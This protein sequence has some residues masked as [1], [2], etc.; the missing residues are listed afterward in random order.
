MKLESRAPRVR[1]WQHHR[2]AG[3]RRTWLGEETEAG[4]ALLQLLVRDK[5]GV[6]AI[7]EVTRMHPRHAVAGVVDVAILVV[8][9][10]MVYGKEREIAIDEFLLLEEVNRHPPEAEAVG[11][12]GAVEVEGL[13]RGVLVLV[14]PP[15][16]ALVPVL[17]RRLGGED[18]IEILAFPAGRL[19]LH[20]CVCVHMFHF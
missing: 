4:E 3:K 17:G 10:E 1:P 16:L 20:L 11:A 5:V 6:V 7:G 12:I 2:L 13:V 9:E 19:P 18:T 8:A 15:A 14:R